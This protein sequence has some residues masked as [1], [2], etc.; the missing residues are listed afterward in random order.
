MPETYKLHI[1]Y[2]SIKILFKYYYISVVT[3]DEMAGWR[4]LLDGRESE[5]TLGVG[6]GPGG[7]ECCD[8]WGRKESDTTERLNWT[9]G[10]NKF[11]MTKW[12]SFPQEFD[13]FTNQFIVEVVS[14]GI[15][16]YPK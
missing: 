4:H 12:N 9:D 3:E 5:W 16:W 1:N 8:S 15:D 2:I 7:L 13:N 6:D 14:L 11:N 10:N